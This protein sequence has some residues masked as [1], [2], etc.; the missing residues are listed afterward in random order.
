MHSVNL[1][2]CDIITK[3]LL[4]SE[5][6]YNKKEDFLN[7]NPKFRRSLQEKTNYFDNQLNEFLLLYAMHQNAE[8]RNCTS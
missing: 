5:T 6:S 4:A 7:P 1:L 3:I 2:M 8:R